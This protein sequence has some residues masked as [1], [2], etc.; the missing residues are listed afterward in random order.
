MFSDEHV[1]SANRKEQDK[2]AAGG[3]EED[4]VEH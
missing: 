3:R 1:I 4:L 2:G